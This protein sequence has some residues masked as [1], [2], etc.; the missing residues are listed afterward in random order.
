MSAAVSAGP[1]DSCSP[2]E[3]SLLSQLER[4]LSQPLGV[5]LDAEP[6]SASLPSPDIE[7]TPEVTLGQVETR[8]AFAVE[9]P[10]VAKPTETLAPDAAK[11]TTE[12]APNK[13][14][15]AASSRRTVIPAVGRAMATSPVRTSSEGKRRRRTVTTPKH[16]SSKHVSGTRSTSAHASWQSQAAP[17]IVP[18][19]ADAR[20]MSP[21]ASELL[22]EAVRA[23][24]AAISPPRTSPGRQPKNA[25]KKGGG[26]PPF[27]V[28]PKVE[29][30]ALAT[31]TTHSPIHEV[32]RGTT[33][34]PVRM[35]AVW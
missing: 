26:K 24:V 21:S 31:S 22:T 32:S 12:P 8:Q 34:S 20:A 16:G 35:C 27:R 9:A 13:Q 25:K 23:T 14:A 18:S 3:P 33:E 1:E 30:D 11:M 29:S 5:A 6:D 7:T 17:Q 10:G 15:P 28:V 19:T 4:I 2:K